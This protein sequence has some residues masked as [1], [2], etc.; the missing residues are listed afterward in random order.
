MASGKSLEISID[1]VAPSY[2]PGEQVT[3]HVVV[4]NATQHP[5]T[6]LSWDSPLDPRAS[7]L[8]VFQ[9][10]EAESSRL[11]E[12][13][14]VEFARK[15]PPN[16]ESYVEIAANQQT[17]TWIK[18]PNLELQ[19]GNEYAIDTRG[20]WKAFWAK[21]FNEIPDRDLQDLTGGISEGFSSS[22]ARIRIA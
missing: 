6:V 20:Q 10:R 4:H 2:Q 17:E 7:I 11:I 13:D 16:R 14:V 9:V 21:G 19:S 22:I 3:L 8:G 15:L 5:V 18:L 1:P 12:G